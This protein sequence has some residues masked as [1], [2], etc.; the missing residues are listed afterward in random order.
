MLRLPDSVFGVLFVVLGIAAIASGLRMPAMMEPAIGPGLMP[1]LVGAGF[2]I[3][4]GILTVQGLPELKAY[5]AGRLRLVEERRNPWFPAVVVLA[6][7]AYVPLLKIVGFAPLTA[8]FIIAVTRASGASWRASLV[9]SAVV[10]AVIWLL[11]S[12][13]LRVPLPPGLLG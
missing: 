11:F 2:L 9:F 8:V 5:A 10:T 6:L 13:L 7:A 3:C 12:R 1:M 4:G